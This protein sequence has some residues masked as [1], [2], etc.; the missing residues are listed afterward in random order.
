MHEG[1]MANPPVTGL[2]AI[3]VGNSRVKLGWYAP[4]D[5]CSTP[6]SMGPSSMGPSPTKSLPMTSMGL[7]MPDDRLDLEGGALEDPLAGS[8]LRKWLDSLPLSPTRCLIASVQHAKLGQLLDLLASCPAAGRLLPPEVLRHDELPIAVRTD[9]PEQ[10]GTDRLLNGV[11]ANYL[12]QPERPAIIV[13][14]GSAITVDRVEADGAF[15]GGAILPGLALSARAL[16]T[17]TDLLPRIKSGET[18]PQPAVVGKNT[19]A[20][21]A[22]GLYWG[23]IGAVREIVRQQMAEGDSP[24]ELFLTGGDALRIAGEMRIQDRPARYQE[25]MVLAGIW[26]VARELS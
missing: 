7:P 15:A 14:M 10:V 5:V 6:S 22:A 26:L 16:H 9:Q 19:S 13:D 4:R 24:C 3:D 8:L 11:T 20:A 17:G 18:Q 25:Q 23:A 21:M 1:S 2:L 12:R